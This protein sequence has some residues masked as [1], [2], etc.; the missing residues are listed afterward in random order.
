MANL[1]TKTYSAIFLKLS[2][3][4]IK[5]I[6]MDN[7]FYVFLSATCKKLINGKFIED[8]SD[9]TEFERSLLNCL[10]TP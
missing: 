7:A 9:A 10:E 3:S 8:N 2:I 4:K 6:L 1:G 5:Y